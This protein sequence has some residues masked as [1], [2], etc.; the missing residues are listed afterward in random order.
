MLDDQKSAVERP[1]ARGKRAITSSRVMNM[2][3]RSAIAGNTAPM[4]LAVS[5]PT[6]EAIFHGGGFAVPTQEVQPVSRPTY[7]VIV[8]PIFYG[9]GAAVPSREFELLKNKVLRGR[10]LEAAGRIKA[11]RG[12]M[13]RWGF[14]RRD[15]ADILGFDDEGSVGELYIGIERVQQRDVRERLK[16]FLSLAVDLDGLYEDNAVIRQW[17]DQPKKL[18]RG[19]TPRALL[20]EGSVESLLHVRHLVRLEANR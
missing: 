11:F 14:T 17:L 5:K 12:L 1:Q 13:E 19:K 16:H 18:L 3:I 15:A 2:P 10:P 7:E 9:G 20:T 4:G 6:N 8:P